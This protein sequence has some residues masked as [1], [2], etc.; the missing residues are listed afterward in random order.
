MHELAMIVRIS[1]GVICG[2]IAGFAAVLAWSM[3]RISARADEAAH[4]VHITY[5]GGNWEDSEQLVRAD[6]EVEEFVKQ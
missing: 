1:L 5:E 4:D 6:K 2:L 3:C